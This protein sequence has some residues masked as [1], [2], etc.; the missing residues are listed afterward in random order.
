MVH[1]SP[2]VTDGTLDQLAADP[3]EPQLA[4]R[5]SE[6]REI[7]AGG[8]AAGPDV[9]SFGYVLRRAVAVLA[10]DLHRLRDFAVHVAVAVIVLREVAVHAL[11]A[12]VHV[13]RRQMHGLLEFLRVV[14]R[15]RAGPAASSRLPLRS[16]L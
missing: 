14:L 12:H 9:R 2:G 11:H 13:N 1:S 6:H 8:P 5:I 4:V 7:A 16:R 15:S 10:V 3:L